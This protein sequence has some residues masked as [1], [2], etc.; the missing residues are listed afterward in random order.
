MN[1]FIPLNF[2]FFWGGIQGQKADA[3]EWENEW[4]QETLFKRHI[5]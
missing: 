1:F 5:D 2:V 4:D 3:K